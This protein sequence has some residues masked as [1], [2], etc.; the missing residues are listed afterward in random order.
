MVYRN[1]SG[2]PTK[3]FTMSSLFRPKTGACVSALDKSRIESVI[4]AH[5]ADAPALPATAEKLLRR[6]RAAG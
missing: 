3:E 1:R 4:E 5:F 6:L 2:V